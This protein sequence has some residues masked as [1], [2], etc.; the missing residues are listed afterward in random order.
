V[1]FFAVKP[2]LDEDNEHVVERPA[3]AAGCGFGLLVD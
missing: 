2:A 1:I 3:L